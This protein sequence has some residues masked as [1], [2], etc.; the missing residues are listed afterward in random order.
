MEDQETRNQTYAWNWFALHAGQ[1]LQLVNFWLVAVAF[2]AAA[3]VQAVASHLHAV[4]ICVSATGPIASVEFVRLDVRTQQLIQASENALQHFEDQF[5]AEGQD[6][7]ILLV[8][9]SAA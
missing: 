9:T 3:F 2:V 4:A 7:S 5:L 6:A 8:R 1:R